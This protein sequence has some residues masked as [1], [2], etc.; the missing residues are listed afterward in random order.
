MWW[1]S[2]LSCVVLRVSITLLK[3]F[4]LTDCFTRYTIWSKPKTRVTR[5]CETATC[6]IAHLST[7]I[8][9]LTFIYIRTL[10]SITQQHIS[11]W[12]VTFWTSRCG[13]TNVFTGWPFAT[14]WICSQWIEGNLFFV[15]MAKYK[16]ISTTFSFTLLLSVTHAE[17][18][19]TY[20]CN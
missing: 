7:C 15:K 20:Y 16:N 11:C 18:H 2:V 17:L 13:M 12:T 6:I 19:Y 10:C 14:W 8:M 1:T 3:R 4:E 5:T 9:V